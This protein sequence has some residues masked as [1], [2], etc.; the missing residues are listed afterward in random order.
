MPYHW[1]TADPQQKEKCLDSQQG[2]AYF[3]TLQGGKKD[4]CLPSTKLSQQENTTLQPI[5]TVSTL[6]AHILAFPPI[7][8]SS[9]PFDRRLLFFLPTSLIAIVGP[10]MKLFLHY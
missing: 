4:F 2:K 7:S 9:S 8:F 10:G 3:A 5:R 1:S 6:K